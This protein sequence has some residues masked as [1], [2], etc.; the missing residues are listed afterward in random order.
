MAGTPIPIDMS[1]ADPVDEWKADPDPAR[2]Q[3]VITDAGKRVVIR[4]EV[5]I[6][7]VQR[8]GNN[9]INGEPIYNIAS[10][11]VVKML[12]WDRDLKTLPK[13]RESKEPP[14]SAYR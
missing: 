10:Q 4:F 3:V 9:P 8:V 14:G 11:N 12:Q 1:K 13:S 2:V 7:G 6:I 5:N